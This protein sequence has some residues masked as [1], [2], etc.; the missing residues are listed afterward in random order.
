MGKQRIQVQGFIILLLASF[1]YAEIGDLELSHGLNVATDVNAVGTI[2]A[3]TRLASNIWLGVG[4]QAEWSSAIGLTQLE[5]EALSGTN[6]DIRLLL[7]PKGTGNAIIAATNILT[8]I[9]VNFVTSEGKMSALEN[10]SEGTTESLELFGF[11]TGD[12]LRSMTV[13]VGED[14]NDAVTFAGL[15]KYIFDG[16]LDFINNALTNVGY[17]DF[18]TGAAAPAQSE[19]RVFYDDDEKTLAVYN[20]E[21]E[22]TLQLGQEMFIRATNKTGSTISNGE[23]VYI[24]GAQGSRPTIALAKADAAAT[25]QVIAMATHDIEDNTT[26]FVTNNGLVHDVNTD[27]ITAGDALFLSATAAGEY[28]DTAPTAPNFIIQIGRVI[29]ENSTSGIIYID[30]GPTA[31]CGTMVIQDLD[32]NTDLDVGEDI[33]AETLVLSKI[34]A[35]AV[36]NNTGDGDG[37]QPAFAFQHQGSTRA[38]VYWDEANDDLILDSQGGSNDG[39]IIF[40]ASGSNR[41]K[42]E[43]DGT[44]AALADITSVADIIS[45]QDIQIKDPTFGEFLSIKVKAATIS[46]ARDFFYDSGDADRT[47]TLSGD[48]TLGDWFDQAV[49]TTSVVAHASGSTF[50]NLTLADGSITDSSNAIDFGNEALSTSGTITGGRYIHT[51]DPDT[52]IDFTADVII[53]EAGGSE[54]VRFSEPFANF[55]R[56]NA[57]S[58]DIDVIFNGDTVADLLKIDAGTET[59]HLKTTTAG[60]GG[61]TNYT[62]IEADGTIELIGNATVFDD[63]RTPMTAIRITGPGGT[64]P[65]DEVLYKGSVVL[66]FGGTGT[67]DEKGFFTIQIPHWYKE[68]TDIVPHIHWTPEDNTAGNVRWVLTYS[69]ANINAAFP[70]ESTDTI[71]IAADETTDKHQRDNFATITGTGKTISS[72]LLCSIQREDSDGTDTYNNKDAYLL[73]IDFHAEKDTMGSRLISDS[74]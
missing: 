64:T 73:E 56:F 14:E 7:R 62:E 55:I 10:A 27:S 46:A 54:F 13:G 63:I 32:I 45:G 44:L 12:Q 70:G 30:I 60:D 3:L 40:K 61:I 72:M 23:L 36:I 47:L 65:P 49:K 50:G 35:Q 26:G 24:N 25:C 59:V 6:T 66:A 2:K 38:V 68:G 43:T 5:L 53:I 16:D 18:E 15:S 29:F 8:I 20:N 28:T 21:A 37:N 9:D 58:E 19:G 74:K 71:V 41:V 48:P 69:W 52:F 33:T 31:V 11:R 51:G 17:I 4:G 22:I 39:E 34:D 67:D 42:I 57:D 1:C